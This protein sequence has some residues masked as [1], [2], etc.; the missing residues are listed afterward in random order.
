MGSGTGLR[1]SLWSGDDDGDYTD[2]FIK[3]PVNLYHLVSCF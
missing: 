3:K 2:L 1:P